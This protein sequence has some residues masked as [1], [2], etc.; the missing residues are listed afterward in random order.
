MD[1]KQKCNIFIEQINSAAIKSPLVSAIME[2]RQ[3]LRRRF[4]KAM[5]LML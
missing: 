4:W 5:E 2:E 1:G 3:N